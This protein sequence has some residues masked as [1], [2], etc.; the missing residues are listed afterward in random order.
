MLRGKDALAF[1]TLLPHFG[2][3]RN[4]GKGANSHHNGNLVW[5][6]LGVE[7]HSTLQKMLVVEW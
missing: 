4:A 3:G 6:L 1:A 5:G 2:L 7:L